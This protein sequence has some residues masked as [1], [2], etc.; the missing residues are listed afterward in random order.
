MTLMDR[1]EIYDLKELFEAVQLSAVLEDGKTFVDCIPKYS[2]EEIETK[3]QQ[4]KARQEFD[5]KA[6]VDS[7]FEMPPVFG[8]SYES[9]KE[10]PVE[11][12]IQQL[13]D[14]LTRKTTDE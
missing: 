3:Y 12:N 4:Q 13:W 11:E 8:A 5:L 14:V 6:F 7:N 1:K 2:L 9:N 10:R